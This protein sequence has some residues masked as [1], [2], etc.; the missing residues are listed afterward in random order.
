MNLPKNQ[1]GRT[2][3]ALLLL[4]AVILYRLCAGFQPVHLP[5]MENFAPVAAVALCGGIYLPR[6]LA[7]LVPLG[8]L[9]VSDIFLNWH[10]GYPLLS[11]EMVSRYLAL[12]AA[13]G[14]GF[15]VRNRPRLATVLPAS[16]LG[17]FI[18]YVMTNTSSWLTWPGYARN[19]AGWWQA[20][21]TGL[22]GYPPT[23]MF[24]RSTLMSDLLF[25]ALF[26]ACMAATRESE[27][28]PVLATQEG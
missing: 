2:A 25:T 8:A 17:S 19:L 22:P 13:V 27:P 14:L 16:L 10:F 26:F 24:F 11:V 4:A 3:A 12:A 15:L 20:L 9:F 5:W 1:T 7:F 21:T 6:R 18:F 28:A 23:W